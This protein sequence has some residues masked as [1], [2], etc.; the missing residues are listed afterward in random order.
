MIITL[1]VFT[2]L[3]FKKLLATLLD[4]KDP[5]DGSLLATILVLMMS[6]VFVGILRVCSGYAGYP[7]VTTIPV[8]TF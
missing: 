7:V 3:I 6:R 5:D 1:Y 2:T 8:L 4:F